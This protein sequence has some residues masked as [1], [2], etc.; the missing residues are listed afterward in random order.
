MR[1]NFDFTDLEV[2][3]AVHKAR[4]FHRA[5]EQLALSQTSVTRRV[6]KLE[7]S[8]GTRLFDRTTREVRPTLAAKRLKLRAESILEDTEETMLAMRDES[9]AFAYQR[10]QNVTIA[11]IPTVIA[12]LVAPALR[13]LREAGHKPRVQILDMSANEV[14][15]AVANADADWGIGSVPMLEPTTEFT[16]LMDDALGLAM[17]PDH[18]LAKR[19]AVLWAALTE[20]PLI[21]P[22]RGTGNRLMMDEALARKQR[23]LRWDMEVGRTTSALALVARGL[24]LAPVPKFAMTDPSSSGLRWRPLKDPDVSRPVGLITRYG[25]AD[26]PSASALKDAVQ[27]IARDVG[28]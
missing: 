15:E 14:A 27:S 28:A 18:P 4:S 12:A 11:A 3:L 26:T 21:L 24:G 23:P 9:A 5:A 2:F 22:A 17:P 19:G 1:I 25:Q 10:A 20:V 6:Q 8:L 13:Q 7:E 16:P